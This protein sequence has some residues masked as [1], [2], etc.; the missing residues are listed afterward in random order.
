MQHD[1]LFDKLNHTARFSNPDLIDLSTNTNPLGMPQ[2]VSQAIAYTMELCNHYP[3]STCKVLRKEI[4]AAR[5]VKPEQVLCSNGADDLIF[6]IAYA[7]RPRKAI[8]LAPTFEEYE[9]ALKLV[10]CEIIHYVLNEMYD[11]SVTNDFLQ[12]LV[13]GIDIVYLCNPNNPTGQVIELA[14]LEKIIRHCDETGILLIVDECFIE[15]VDNAPFYSCRRFIDDFSN[16]VVIEAFTKLYAM[17]GLR[18]G[19]CM[20]SNENLLQQLAHA[21][22]EWNVSIPAQAGGI[23]ALNDYEYL[24]HTRQFVCHERQWM[25]KELDKCGI[26]VIGSKANYLFFKSLIPNLRQVLS[27]KDIL[28]RNCE[29]FRGLPGEYCRV[30]IKSHQ[31]N[32]IF[33]SALK[34]LLP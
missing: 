1:K 6:R 34:E 33:L 14:L 29:N 8:V 11:F 20:S 30:A 15:F 17:A 31:S 13:P 3:D 27:Q 16:L 22:Q 25:I 10:N 5:N 7:V 21:G 26:R 12:M 19:F 23:A 28:I 24:E 9:S 18:L 4:A 2:S 32:S